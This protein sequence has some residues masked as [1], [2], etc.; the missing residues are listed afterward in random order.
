MNSENLWHAWRWGEIVKAL[1]SKDPLTQKSAVDAITDWSGVRMGKNR[2]DHLVEWF[3]SDQFL[4]I[5]QHPTWP[6]MISAGNN[7]FV[8]SVNT[9]L[10]IDSRLVKNL[11]YSPEWPR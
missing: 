8:R 11:D 4:S 9:H 5:H 2:F 10:E 6:V 3:R 1:T 7:V